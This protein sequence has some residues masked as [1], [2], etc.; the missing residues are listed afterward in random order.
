M[1]GVPERGVL[2]RACCGRGSGGG[3][4]GGLL[5]SLGRPQLVAAPNHILRRVKGLGVD[6]G[7]DVARQL[8]DE[9]GDRLIRKQQQAF[10]TVSLSRSPPP[11]SSSSLSVIL[12]FS[13]TPPFFKGIDRP[14][15]R[16]VKNSLIRSLFKNWRLR[17]FFSLILKGFHH[18]IS[19]K[20]KDA[21]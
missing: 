17:N 3:G 12:F 5:W 19:K 13:S 15:L 7:A 8:A 16:G 18:K 4:G 14:F 1:L 9:E 10:A 21:A 11:F 2:P 6:H 20:P